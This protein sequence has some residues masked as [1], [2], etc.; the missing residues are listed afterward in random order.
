[1]HVHFFF[2][3][4]L[5]YLYMFIFVNKKWSR[6][7]VAVCGCCAFRRSDGFRCRQGDHGFSSSNRTFIC[8]PSISCK[9]KKEHASDYSTMKQRTPSHKGFTFLSLCKL[10]W[11]VKVLVVELNIC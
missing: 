10:L 7:T 2:T 5:A 3:L 9:K 8:S 11:N 4:L 6:L 1:M